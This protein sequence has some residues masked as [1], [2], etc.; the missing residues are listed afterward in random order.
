MCERVRT[1]FIECKHFSPR[2]S[3][4][5]KWPKKLLQCLGLKWYYLLNRYM[6]YVFFN[7]FKSPEIDRMASDVCVKRGKNNNYKKPSIDMHYRRAHS[8][9]SYLC[10]MSG[11][12]FVV[13][14]I[15]IWTLCDA[16]RNGSIYRVGI[17][18]LP[19]TKKTGFAWNVS[20]C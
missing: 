19:C 9:L 18:R 13:G 10:C 4:N 6:F 7:N 15:A 20:D 11:N 14:F 3:F 1:K 17:F 8:F 5:W 2:S 12:M 16:R